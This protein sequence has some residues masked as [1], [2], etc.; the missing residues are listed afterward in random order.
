MP[1]TIISWFSETSPPRRLAGAISATGSIAGVAGE[2]D[3][4][5]FAVAEARSLVP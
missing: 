3:H 2:I 5:V 1:M 4:D